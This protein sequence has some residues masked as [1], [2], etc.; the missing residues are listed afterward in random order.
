MTSFKIYKS[1]RRQVQLQ[2]PLYTGGT[3]SSEDLF[4]VSQLLRVVDG[5]ELVPQDSAVRSSL[6]LSTILCSLFSDLSL[7]FLPIT[8]H[9]RVHG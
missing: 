8:S 2:V 6:R 1:L 7:S 9:P 5:L 3:H 4:K